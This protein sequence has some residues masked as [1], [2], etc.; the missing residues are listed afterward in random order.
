MD[1]LLTL[2][3]EDGESIKDYA[4][5]FWETCNDIDNCS[6]DVAVRTFKLGL[7]LEIGLRQSLTKRPATTLRKLMDRIEQF[8]RVEEDGG[9]TTSKQTAVQPKIMIPKPPTQPNNSAKVPQASSNFVAPSFQAFE[10]VFK[11]PIYKILNKIKDKPYFVWP[12]KLLGDPVSRD[13]KLQCS[14]HRDK[15]HMTEN[16]HMLKTHLEQL[17]SAGHLDQ[18]I[19]T[20]LSAKRDPNNLVWRPN[21]PVAASLGVIHVIHN[22]LCSSIMPSSYTSKIQKEF[23]LRRSY[24]IND[25][26]HLVPVRPS[27]EGPLN[28]SIFFSNSDLKDVQLPHNDPLVITL[29]IRN[30]DV[31]R[32]LIDQGSFAEV[33]YYDMYKK[34][35][36]GE[37]DLTSFVSPV[38]GF[39]GESIIPRG[40]DYF[41]SFGRT[42]QSTDQVPSSPGIISL[43]CYYG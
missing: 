25:S 26:A 3:L 7:P 33:M 19:D 40:K 13:P 1:A 14:Y 5:R 42:D 18:Y 11:E 6:E 31:R 41:T 12:P 43:Q 36:L 37:A 28:Q 22:P 15:G 24:A 23:H 21:N 32:V 35:G 16:C 30:F 17:A 20:N 27:T 29:R 10:T 9:N 38:F 39:S 2:K 34:L 4:T 8:I